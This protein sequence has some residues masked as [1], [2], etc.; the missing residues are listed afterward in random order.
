MLVK[1]C[2]VENGPIPLN[3]P[4]LASLRVQPAAFLA[5]VP[6]ENSTWLKLCV[7]GWA[8]FLLT[9]CLLVILARERWEQKAVALRRAW[10]LAAAAAV[11]EHGWDQ[12]RKQTAERM[13]EYQEREE[14]IKTA[15]GCGETLVFDL[16]A[17]AS[18][19]A[20]V[21][22][23]SAET[24]HKR[25]DLTPEPWM[26]PGQNHFL[27]ACRAWGGLVW[28]WLNATLCEVISCGSCGWNAG[29]ALLEA[30]QARVMAEGGRFLI[31]KSLGG[32]EEFWK[33]QGFEHF[34]GGKS[35]AWLYECSA[36]VR[37]IMIQFKNQ[38]GLK[39]FVKKLPRVAQASSGPDMV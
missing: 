15:I 29:A 28:R 10:R 16:T 3:H 1:Y 8:A 23:A 9:A 26:E 13:S 22:R 31:L 12:D 24:M 7:V 6:D 34:A 30:M 21:A 2:A 35:V 4:C 39:T 36:E 5:R 14:D 17:P 11:M 38:S 32:A 19:G 37:K 25:M 18:F 33:K 20:E 27:A